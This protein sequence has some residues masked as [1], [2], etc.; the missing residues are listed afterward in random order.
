MMRSNVKR[1]R[2][3]KRFSRQRMIVFIHL[4]RDGMMEAAIVNTLSPGDKVLAVTIGYS[5]TDS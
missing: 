5:E 4:F 3:Q 1:S 2:W